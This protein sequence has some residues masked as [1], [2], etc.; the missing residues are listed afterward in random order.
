M[1]FWCFFE[2]PSKRP[3]S[4]KTLFFLSK[5]TIFQ[6]W[7]HQKSLQKRIKNSFEKKQW[8][9]CT[10]GGFLERFWSQ[11]SMIFIIFGIIFSFHIFTRKRREKVWKWAPQSKKNLFSAGYANPY[12]LSLLSCNRS[13]PWPNNWL[14]QKLLLKLKCAVQHAHGVGNPPRIVT[15]RG[16]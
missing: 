1:F 14:Q 5:I 2:L 16:A 6:V 12:L 8:N 4:R 7:S 9:K 3:F 10:F 11:K 13:K 15:L